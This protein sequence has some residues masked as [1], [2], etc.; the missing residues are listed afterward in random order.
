M[1]KTKV[2]TGLFK[3]IQDKCS[4]RESLHAARI[5][6]CNEI[7]KMFLMVWEDEKPDVTGKDWIKLTISP[8]ARNKALGAIRLMTAT[9]PKFRDRKSVV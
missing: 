5:T 6:M 7:E 9:D 1:A 4:E 3:D 2:D 8:E